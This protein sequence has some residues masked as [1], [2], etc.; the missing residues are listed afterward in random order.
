MS[1]WTTS[2]GSGGLGASMYG[3]AWKKIG[4]A[5]TMARPS[6]SPHPAPLSTATTWTLL[7]FVLYESLS[8]KV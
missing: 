1:S 2:K 5:S 8:A 4:L 6:N 3:L 7:E